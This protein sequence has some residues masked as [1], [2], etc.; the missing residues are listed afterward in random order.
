MA[1]GSTALSNRDVK[2]F[3]TKSTSHVAVYFGAGGLQLNIPFMKRET[4]SC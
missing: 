1:K 3:R 4:S 2:N